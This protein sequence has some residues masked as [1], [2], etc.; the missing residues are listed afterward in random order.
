MFINIDADEYELIKAMPGLERIAKR[1]EEAK[2]ELS[3]YAAEIEQARD[4]Y[5]LP[6]D[7]DLEIDDEPA[8]SIA[9]NGVWVSAWVW[10]RT[11][12]D[13]DADDE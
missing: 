1:Y 3:S 8:L 6:S 9:D 11:A 13:E 4:E 10:V 2:E 5:A 7:D 12:N